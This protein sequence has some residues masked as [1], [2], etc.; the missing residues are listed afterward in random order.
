MRDSPVLKYYGGSCEGFYGDGGHR[1]S[2]TEWIMKNSLYWT[3]RPLVC[4]AAYSLV[5]WDFVEKEKRTHKYSG[6]LGR[7]FMSPFRNL[8]MFCEF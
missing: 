8:N 4:Q 3:L 2:E 6:F 5:S 7:T 1:A